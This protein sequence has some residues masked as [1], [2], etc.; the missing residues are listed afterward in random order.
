MVQYLLTGI[1][2][3]IDIEE[4]KIIVRDLLD[5][6]IKNLGNEVNLNK[7]SFTTKDKYPISDCVRIMM[8]N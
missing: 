4:T 6:I 7:Y 2:Q 1:V 5:Y 8:T 3:K